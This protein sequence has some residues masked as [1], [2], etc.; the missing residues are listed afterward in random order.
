MI[1]LNPKFKID[2]D[3]KIILFSSKLAEKNII[4]IS[5]AISS[6]KNFIDWYKTKGSKINCKKEY[7]DHHY[8]EVIKPNSDKILQ[9]ASDLHASLKETV[10]EPA[11][12]VMNDWTQDDYLYYW[13]EIINRHAYKIVFIDG[14][15]YSKGCIYEY[16]IGLNKGIEL[17]DNNLNPI[18]KCWAIQ[19]IKNSINEYEVIG[20]NTDLQRKILNEIINGNFK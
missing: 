12:F 4:Y 10:V 18:N 13:S 16:L 8:K 6:G 14:W 19:Q 20:I 9:I 2:V 5:S 15:F 1:H 17:L 7:N 3:Q 11:S